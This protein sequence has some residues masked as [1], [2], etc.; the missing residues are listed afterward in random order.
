MLMT[1]DNSWNDSTTS[2]ALQKTVRRTWYNE[3]LAVPTKLDWE[4]LKND[5]WIMPRIQIHTYGLI[6]SEVIVIASI[7][8]IECSLNAEPGPNKRE[9]LWKI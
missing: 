5:K 4:L 9:M 7:E 1:L 2:S 8:L 3:W 6:N